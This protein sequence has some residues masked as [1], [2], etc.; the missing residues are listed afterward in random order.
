MC[1]CL[2]M[3]GLGIS[4]KLANPLSFSR[5]DSCICVPQRR[6]VRAVAEVYGCCGIVHF[7]L[8]SQRWTFRPRNLPF[9]VYGLG[10]KTRTNHWWH[11]ERLWAV[12]RFRGTPYGRQHTR[13]F[14]GFAV[15]WPNRA[16]ILEVGTGR[17]NVYRQ[18]ERNHLRD[19]GC[20]PRP[21]VPDDCRISVQAS[22]SPG[23]VVYWG[24]RTAVRRRSILPAQ[25]HRN[26]PDVCV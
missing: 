18:R 3:A 2:L 10:K 15:V 13:R 14:W 7:I 16:K 25:V 23:K 26:Q 19:D 24:S 4:T 9:E 20:F 17:K 8:C 5:H 11:G 6:R 21:Q 12:Q 22:P 1:L